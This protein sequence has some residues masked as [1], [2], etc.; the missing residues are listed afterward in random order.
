MMNL[1]KCI[2]S[3]GAEVYVNAW[4]PEDAKAIAE[5]DAVECGKPGLSVDRV[6]DDNAKD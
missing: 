5:A 4:T 1:Y 6:V 2:F 3:N